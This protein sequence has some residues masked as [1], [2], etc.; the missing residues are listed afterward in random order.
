[1]PIRARRA[2]GPELNL[3]LEGEIGLLLAP[4]T[5]LLPT[6]KRGTPAGGS[7]AWRPH[8]RA[9]GRSCA[10]EYWPQNK[11]IPAQ[12]SQVRRVLKSEFQVAFKF[13]KS[14]TFR[15]TGKGHGANGQ[16]PGI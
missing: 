11:R 5:Q 15:H 12:H 10:P 1:M 6:A 9:A 3:N 14:L 8:A 7:D 13:P 16:L 2:S 4:R